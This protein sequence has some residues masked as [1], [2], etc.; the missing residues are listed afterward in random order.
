MQLVWFYSVIKLFTHCTLVQICAN[1]QKKKERKRES[2]HLPCLE[3]CTV[4]LDL[5][6][7]EV[8]SGLSLVYMESGSQFSSYQ[9]QMAQT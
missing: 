6:L 8:T 7:S 4:K 1:I 2:V 9:S 3:A 5:G